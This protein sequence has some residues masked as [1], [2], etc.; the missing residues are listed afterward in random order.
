MLEEQIVVRLSAEGLTV[1]Q[2]ER[3]NNDLRV[4]FG[5]DPLVTLAVE[6]DCLL[7]RFAQAAVER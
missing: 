5:Q 3:I 4:M 6:R 7:V 2:V 1:E